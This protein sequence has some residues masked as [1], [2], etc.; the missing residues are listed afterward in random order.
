MKDSQYGKGTIGHADPLFGGS[1]PSQRRGDVARGGGGIGEGQPLALPARP[2]AAPARFDN[3]GAEQ[4][5]RCAYLV[6]AADIAGGIE[7]DQLDRR[8]E[9]GAGAMIHGRILGRRAPSVRRL[10]RIK[11][12]ELIH[13]LNQF[14]PGIGGRADLRDTRPLECQRASAR[15]GRP[16]EPGLTRDGFIQARIASD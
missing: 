10:F 8:E 5:R 2:D 9:G 16:R 4:I 6:A 11:K 15:P 7:R 1:A 13:S 14:R 12:P 3:D